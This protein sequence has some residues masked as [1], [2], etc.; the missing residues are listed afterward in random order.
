MHELPWYIVERQNWKVP[1]YIVDNERVGKY[2]WRLFLGKAQ[3][4]RY[5]Y[6]YMHVSD[7]PKSFLY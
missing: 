1:W 5:V 6:M 2:W 7:T 3:F 4:S